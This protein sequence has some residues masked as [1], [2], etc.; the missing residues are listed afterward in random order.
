MQDI[1]N[2]TIKK[3]PF[4]WNTNLKK[5]YYR[6]EWELY[7]LKFDPEELS[8]IANKNSSKEIFKTL[9]KSLYLWLNKTKDPWICSPHAVL[10]NSGY[11]T[12]NPQCLS[13]LNY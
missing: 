2:K 13:L 9:Q 1:L 3:I 11:Y 8:N 12:N 7:D 10:E 4:K 6:D 5:Y